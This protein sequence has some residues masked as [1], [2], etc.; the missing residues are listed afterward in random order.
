MG[1]CYQ[2]YHQPVHALPFGLFPCLLIE[3]LPIFPG[4]IISAPHERLAKILCMRSPTLDKIHINRTR[5][6]FMTL[7]RYRVQ[8]T[9]RMELGQ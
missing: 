6:E 4:K 3:F 7:A 5:H 8:M 2:T 1:G 9:C